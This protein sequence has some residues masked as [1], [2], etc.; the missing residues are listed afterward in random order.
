MPLAFDRRDADQLGGRTSN[1]RPTDPVGV[2]HLHDGNRTF[3][4]VR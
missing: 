2:I 1:L 4:R 3:D